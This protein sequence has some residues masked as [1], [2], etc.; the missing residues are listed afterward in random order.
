MTQQWEALIVGIDEYPIFTTLHNLTVARKDA[1]DITQTLNDYGYESFRIQ[2]LPQ[3]PYQKGED[4]N[5]VKLGVRLDELKDKITHLFNPPSQQET[6]DLALFFFSGHG[7]HQV[8]NGDDDVF[9]ATSDV[10]PNAGIY[11]LSLRWLGGEIEKSSVK[12]VIIWL[13]C[14][15]SGE[16][17]KYLPSNKDYCFITG[18]RSFET[19]LEISYSQGLFTKTLLEGL[20]PD[21]YPDGIVDSNK[22]K[23]F[24]EKQ[25]KTTSQRPLIKNSQRSILLTN[26][27]SSQKFRDECPYRS[28]SYFRDTPEDAT[29]FWGRSQLTNNLIKRVQES[30]F[31]AVLG[32]SGSGKS[33]L[34]RAGLLYQLKLGQAIAESNLWTYLTPFSPTENPLKELND[35][36][37]APSLTFAKDKDKKSK[38][39][40]NEERKIIMIIDQFEECFTMCDETTRQAFFDRLIELLDEH[41]NLHIIIGMRSDFRGRLREHT[42][43]VNKIEKPYINVEHL[44]R[45]EI[46]EIIKKPADL[47][48]LQI[49]SSLQQQLINDV[50]D[51]PGS[52]PLLEYTL[53]QLWQETRKQ[54]ERFLTLKTYQGLGG[55][56][57]TLEK[58][59]DEVFN[60]LDKNEQVIAK[61]IFLELTQVGN[62]FDT[63]RR[64][65]LHELVNSHH[66]LE[67]LDQ[68]TQKLADEKNRLIVRTQEETPK[69][70]LSTILIDVV[71]EAL[72]RNWGMLREWKDEYQEGMVTERKIEAAAAEWNHQQQKPEY[73]LQGSKL[74]EAQEYIK[75]YDNLGMLDGIAETYIER[76]IKRKTF[77]TGRNWS[78]AIAVILG[79]S[80]GLVF[81]LIGYRNTL[82]QEAI[83]SR[84]SAETSLRLNHSLD[85]MIQSLQAG[86]TLQHPLVKFP[87][88]Q[89]FKSTDIVQED[90][91]ATLQWAVYRVKEVNRMRGDSSMIVRS[92]VS[93]HDSSE[94]VIAS[95]TENGTIRLWNLQGKLLKSWKVQSSENQPSQRIWNV[96]FSPDGKL[97]ASSGEDGF[98]RLW[99]L[100]EIE[101]LPDIKLSQ[102]PKHQAIKAYKGYD[103]G[104]VRYVTFSPD[105]KKL[106]ILEGE[107]GNGYIGF[108]DLQGNKLAF[109]KADNN[110]PPV[111]FVKSIDF[112]P[113]QN[114]DIIVTLGIDQEI[115]IWDTKNVNLSRQPRLLSTLLIPKTTDIKT[116]QTTNK[117]KSWGAFFSPDGKYI[118]AAGDDGSLALW[119]SENGLWG[120]QDQKVAKVWQAHKGII[121]NVAFSP[122]SQKIASGGEDGNVRIWNLKGEK[123]AQFDG[124]NG[125]VRSVKFTADSQQLVSS[126][127]DGTTRLWNLPEQLFDNKTVDYLPKA[128]VNNAQNILSS[129]NNLSAFVDQD[130]KIKIRD[131]SGNEL[132]SFQDHIGKV[133]AI[134]F[135]SNSQLLV[136][137]GQDNTIRVWK[138]LHKK[139]EGRYSSIFQVD[140]E[141]KIN[142]VIFSPDNQRIIAGDNAGYIRV[143]GLKQ[144][145]KIAFWQVSTHAI[146]NLSFSSDG[147]LLVTFVGQENTVKLSLE[148]FDKLMARGCHDL[149]QFLKNNPNSIS[150]NTSLCQEKVVDNMNELVTVNKSIENPKNAENIVNK[151]LNNNQKSDTKSLQKSEI[152]DYWS[153]TWNHSFIGRNNQSLKGT[154]TL[155]VKNNQVTGT[156]TIPTRNLTGKISEGKITNNGRTLE[157]K[158]SN[159]SPI[160]GNIILNLLP[161]NQ[162]FSGYY[163]IG[164]QEIGSNSA[165]VWN[166]VRI[167]E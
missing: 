48:G 47:V 74:G 14:C 143:W 86:Q 78:V 89:L 69:N 90:I 8:V 166:A 99:N 95:A 140:N 106:A 19:G 109:W 159:S 165:N 7:W 120:S 58:R 144:N 70:S 119:K 6:P 93:P 5:Q 155:E 26:R 153:G 79:L 147:H 37:V 137:A 91:E 126:A 121:W 131:A 111:N 161:N 152:N 96:S 50:E 84:N 151:F 16:L 12:K 116:S 3:Q 102:T 132:N 23:E 80:T 125:P 31:I 59:A 134:N 103:Q 36:L 123:I 68:V 167:G 41:K 154:M 105:G 13:D 75:N 113:D 54:G 52:L 25:M 150:I 2:R 108:W 158:W 20:N 163:S 145:R 63:R 136:S 149:K 101:K 127:D 64:V 39:S 11:G 46:E 122:D 130:N 4:S 65:Y 98:V 57:G 160:Q 40:T 85:G 87:L 72:I 21:N 15:F 42:K 162:E 44:K 88:F 142:T 45:E 24:I 128:E 33:S 82:I 22:L 76:S 73:L 35:V 100:E 43:L 81:S 92:V 38:F 94:Q 138:N 129:D 29:F 107:G 115:K 148:S 97:L 67:Q 77:N 112:Y 114:Q 28:L 34:L 27:Y 117:F 110:Q 135:S 83:S 32:A 49:E 146:K 53:T 51:Y 104:Y 18:T 17:I 9:L 62:K 61:R 118:V 156:F 71:H 139:Q 30:R 124:H 133:L 157:G 164:N 60:S 56:E 10:Y 55:I 1:E 66:T 141:N